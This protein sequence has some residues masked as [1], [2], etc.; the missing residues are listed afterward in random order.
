T[1][2]ILAADGRGLAPARAVEGAVATMVQPAAPAAACLAA[3]GA[4]ACTDVTGFGLLGHLLEM[5]RASDRD[6]ELDPDAIPALD[7]ALGL[8]SRGITSSLHSDNL[9]ALARL[10]PGEAHPIAA[11]L[12]DPQTA[13]GLLAGVPAARAA[14]CLAKLR[15]RGY[16]AAVIGRILRAS[17]REPRV[18]LE[19]GA[20][21][22]VPEP[23]TAG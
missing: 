10:E 8:L 9:A 7:G 4:S 17:G 20:A 2:V 11:L 5:L 12:I 22:L 23:V 3:H 13:G 6:A 19:P 1:G 18:R 14:A 15:R 16:R 21:E